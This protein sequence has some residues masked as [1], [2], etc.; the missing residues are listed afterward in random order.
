MCIIR[1]TPGPFAISVRGSEPIGGRLKR[2]IPTDSLIPGQSPSG[3]RL[4]GFSIHEVIT[5]SGT[6]IKMGG[7]NV[8]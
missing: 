5:R 3:A 8:R 1:P 4:S 6:R 7:M 2:A